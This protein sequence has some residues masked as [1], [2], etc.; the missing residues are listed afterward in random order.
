M[1]FLKNEKR[2]SF[3]YDGKPVW[4]HPMTSVT[5]ESENNL[6]VTYQLPDGLKI[7]HI[8]TRYPAF[9]AWEW[10]TW[11]ENTGASP[12]QVISELWDADF[13]MP[14]PH[15]DKRGAKAFVGKPEN[16]T[17]IYAPDGSNWSRNEFYCDVDAMEG[18]QFYNNHA[19]PGWAP[20]TYHSRGGRSSDLKAPFFNVHYKGTGVVFAIGWSGQWNASIARQ[21][22]S[23]TIQTKIEDTNFRLLAGEKVR[24][25]SFVIMPYTGDFDEAQNK[26]RRLIKSSFSIIGKPGRPA[27]L[28][29]CAGIWGGMQTCHALDRIHLIQEK[30]LPFEYIWMDAGWYG[31]GTKES[32]DEFEGDWG[33][34]TGNWTVNRTYHPDGLMEVRDAIRKAGM[35][36]LLWFEP[37]RVISDTPIAS[38]H[39]EYFIGHPNGHG[40]KNLLLNLGNEHAWQYCF[41]TLAQKI[42]ELE[43]DCYRNDFNFEPLEYWRSRDAWDRKGI[44]E[45][46]YINGL[47]RLW[48]ALL[49]RF[50]HLFIDDCASGGRRI[51]IEML[52]RSV[53]L[54]RSDAQCPADW[55]INVTQ[56][57]NMNFSTWLPYSGTGSGREWGDVYRIR[58]AYAAGLTT[59]YTFSARTEFGNDP[60]QLEW[61][62]KYLLEYQQAR[63]FFSEDFYPLTHRM[64][65]EDG[66]CAS[67]FNRPEQ[68]DGM[69]QVFKREHSPYS[70]AMLKLRGLDENG[71]YEFTDADDQSTFTCPGQ[72]LMS[73]GLRME[74]TGSRIAKLFF[75][76]KLD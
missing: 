62:R 35:K 41:D 69:I 31:N 54:W 47:Y 72:E 9:D 23:L 46:K 43:I 33:A 49:E 17:R 24:T 58:S 34:H 10:V 60:E 30:Q 8:A 40:S 32:P 68:A 22:D 7:T 14:F 1:D 25:S 3:L 4:E 6:T 28:P 65:A 63:P 61:I 67:Q 48:D 71:I 16:A 66:W 73:S 45:I 57:H 52:K 38:E 26:W 19:Y 2:F 13:T 27:Q 53:P 75:Y 12:S 36:Y 39:P 55:P 20:R 51:D 5:E 74:I 42:Q 76:K 64:S 37:E 29:L 18:N 70:V 21:E 44:T 50:P 59:N 11:F 15:Q 56:H